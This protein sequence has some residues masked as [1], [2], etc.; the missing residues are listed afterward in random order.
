MRYIQQVIQWMAILTLTFTLSGCNQASSTEIENVEA[1]K[2]IV[3]TSTVAMSN[4]EETIELPG[5]VS[6]RRVA[7]VRARVSGLVL[8]RDFQEGQE[9]TAGQA[10]FHI[11]AAEFKAALVQAEA[12]LS[13]AKANL[14]DVKQQAERYR[15]LLKTKSVSRQKYD[16]AFANFKTAQ[17][18]LQA[19][20]AAVDAA[21]LKL[22]Y[23]TVTAPI[24]GRIGRALVTEGALVGQG[25]ATHLTTIQQLDTIYVDMSQP[26]TE[27]LAL[28]A[29]VQQAE[30]SNSSSELTVSLKEINYTAHGT[31]LFSDVTV[32]KGTGQVSLRGLFQNPDRMLLPG[33]YVRVKI[34]VGT[35]LQTTFLPQSA[36]QLDASGAPYVFVLTKNQTVQKRSIKTGQ[37]RSNKWQVLEGLQEGETVVVE[38]GSNLQSGMQ[39]VVKEHAQNSA[40][41]SSSVNASL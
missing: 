6:A 18:T 7:Q 31:L 21:K 19:A 1:P 9:V 34:A 14:F 17:A 16:T 23:T 28:K 38:G 8:S 27:Y 39:V 26:V 15:S 22:S 33:M 25:E 2:P 36:I 35:A 12:E 29:M 37:M 24:A 10:L 20:Q 5:R 32:D 40:T 41:P 4:F 11:E 30:D 13:K 3:K